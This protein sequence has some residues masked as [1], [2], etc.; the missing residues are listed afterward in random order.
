MRRFAD[1]WARESDFLTAREM[2]RAG[3]RPL[4]R[5]DWVE[6]ATC[7]MRWSDFLCQTG[8]DIDSAAHYAK[9]SIDLLTRIGDT[10]RACP[11]P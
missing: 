5:L 9:A 3:H 6:A 1:A 10:D 2:G 11:M 7:R 8:G 4:H